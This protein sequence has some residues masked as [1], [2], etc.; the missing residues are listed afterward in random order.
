[1]TVQPRPLA[2]S[3]FSAPEVAPQEAKAHEFVVR[4]AESTEILV[5]MAD[6][7]GEVGR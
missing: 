5:R 7:R 3:R 6:G 1:M 2:S 4:W